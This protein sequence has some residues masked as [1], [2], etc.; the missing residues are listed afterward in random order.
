MPTEPFIM[1]EQMM[2]EKMLETRYLQTKALWQVWVCMPAIS[3]LGAKKGRKR[4]VENKGGSGEGG[5][6]RA[7][8]MS[9]SAMCWLC[10]PEN[11]SSD[12]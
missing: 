5:G 10:M 12:R 11:L 9:L 6:G 3:G 2:T 7:G 4:R 1:F 8:A